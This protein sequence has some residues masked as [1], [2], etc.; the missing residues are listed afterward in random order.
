MPGDSTEG[1]YPEQVISYRQKGDWRAAEGR[2]KELLPYGFCFII[3]WRLME[4]F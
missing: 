2:D 3:F 4:K 1:N